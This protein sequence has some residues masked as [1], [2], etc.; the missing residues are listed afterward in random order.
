MS[1]VEQ[2]PNQP[3]ENL[4][5]WRRVESKRFG[6]QAFKI[7]AVAAAVWWWAVSVPAAASQPNFLFIYT[8][9][10][11]YDTLGVVQREQAERGRFPWFTT[12]NLDR[13]AAE[14]ARFR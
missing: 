7:A 14:G 1:A 8:D 5:R 11:R 2:G 10:Q 4:S 12:P 3:R 9:D 13:L 6:M